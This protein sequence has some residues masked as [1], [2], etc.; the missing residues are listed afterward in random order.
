MAGLFEN[1]ANSASNVFE[2]EDEV[3]AELGKRIEAGKIHY[4]VSQN[5]NHF[6][7]Y[8][9]MQII[10]IL[11]RKHHFVELHSRTGQVRICQVRTCKSRPIKLGKVKSIWVS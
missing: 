7:S 11:I 10:Q 4:R 3:E 8:R 2:V 6:K 5:L 1:K 9:M